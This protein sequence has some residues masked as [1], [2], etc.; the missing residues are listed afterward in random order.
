MKDDRVP[1]DDRAVDEDLVAAEARAASVVKIGT[2]EVQAS[3]S[4]CWRIYR[5]AL[6]LR[7]ELG[8]K[9]LTIDGKTAS[10]RHRLIQSVIITPQ[11]QIS[12]AL[13]DNWMMVPDFDTQLAEVSD[14][15]IIPIEPNPDGTM[16]EIPD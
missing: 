1:T 8:G 13:V 9:V 15:M 5:R 7:N 16:P 3:A 6:A 10:G 12:V 14:A 4:L 2:L 11:T